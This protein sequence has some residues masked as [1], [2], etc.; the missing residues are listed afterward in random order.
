MNRPESPPAR[1]PRAWTMAAIPLLLAAGSVVSAA[2]SV[3]PAPADPPSSSASSPADAGGGSALGKPDSPADPSLPSNIEQLDTLGGMTQ[4]RLR[5]NGMTLLLVPNHSAPVITFL[6]VYHVGSR[7][8]APGNTGSA[9]LL[10]HMLFNKST[11]NFGRANG[12]R[13]FQEVLFE[14]GAD[15]SSSNMTT[16]YDRMTGYSTLPANKLE[17]AMRIASDRLGRGLILD[18][19]RQPEMSVVRNEYEIGENNPSQ[20]LFKAVIA[21]AIVAHPYHW[22]TIGYRSDI[23]GVSTETLRQHYRDF[24]WPDNTDAVLVGDFEPDS[25]LALFDREFGAF[26]HS[27]RPIPKV[28]TV[29][30]PQ[31]GE[32][33]VIVRRPGSVGI[34]QIAYIRP[35]ALDPD[36]I[37]IEVLSEI[38]GDGINSRLYQ[39]LVETGQASDVSSENF[40]LRD[41]YP[42]LL[43]ATV[44]PSSTHE[45]V[46]ATLK[47]TLYEVAKNGVTPEE[48]ERAKKQ[49]EVSVIRGRD[50]TYRL[51]SSL[52]EAIASASWQWFVGYPDA[53][54]SVTADDV[55][56]VASKYLIPDHATVGWFVPITEE[57]GVG[58][59]E[60][61]AGSGKAEG[62]AG[63]G[64]AAPGSAAGENTSTA[65]SATSAESTAKSTNASAEGSSSTAQ[66]S[67]AEQKASRGETAAATGN[68]AAS[69]SPASAA[70]RAT[71]GT[72]GSQ[73][74]NPI[75]QPGTSGSPLGASGSR[76]G[77]SASRSGAS[78]SQSGTS[79]P[80]SGASASQSRTFEDRT[81]HRVLPN[82]VIL[83]IVENPQA[84]NVS[85]SG[86][87]FA[88][89]VLAP[90]GAPAV[91][92][93]T[94]RMLSRGTTSR[95]KLEIASLLDGAGA[96]LQ[97]N[98]NVFETDITGSSLS[99]DLPLLLEILADELANPAFSD[100]ELEKA[101][102]E[103]KSDV[104]R[105]SE[106]T[107]TR[108]HE[109][110]SQIVYPKGH[111][112]HAPTTDEMLQS[113][114]A[115]SRDDIA[116]FHRE[117]FVGSS[118]ILAISGD[119]DAA[120]TASLIEK[121]FGGLPTGTRPVMDLPRVAPGPA[122][123][124]VVT[125]PGKANM[126]FVFGFASG[127][128]RTDPDYDA[129]VLA[130]AA[131]G[132]DA[133][134]SRI[135][136]RVRD[137]EGLS[138]YL[139]SR[140]LMSD[141]LDGEW[142]V[143]VAVA[144]QNLEKAMRS[145]REEFE[146]YCR[147]GI[148][149][150]ELRVQKSHFAGNYQVRLGSNAGIAAALVE[151]E[152]FG[153]GP[154]YLDDYP[155]RI[156]AVTR[157]QVDAAIRDH[158]HPENLSLVVAGD[159][160]ELPDSP[161]PGR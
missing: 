87:V 88:G 146:K 2:P 90:S 23:E 80:Q 126:D 60:G 34:V 123:R 7:N 122:E 41:P 107:Y 118:L 108:A 157:E 103:M 81:T 77:T 93:L 54:Q 33:R 51:A 40:T 11:E 155:A 135:G 106:Q 73:S 72:P 147:E 116:T 99:A 69:T 76:S 149:D 109:R 101:K 59:P 46:E 27:S 29:E 112:L 31:E 120:A 152:K 58:A 134:S 45:Q 44:A 132:Q 96:R 127:L 70:T 139:Y 16:W 32:R 21:A 100:E 10:E 161:G 5:S 38:L 62:G 43:E 8:E 61:A 130:N 6:M 37:P 142:M 156:R 53:I 65:E 13:T 145:T 110:L 82:G 18:S 83:D 48:L 1:F 14:A 159:I 71:S 30:P 67:S 105:A 49:I 92:E 111:P 26:P 22:D 75:S 144:P 115:A 85:L 86:L 128:R 140:F 68:H 141:L 98:S 129:A 66:L 117:H 84:P 154:A 79:G 150:E 25:A 121:D 4:Y 137:T 97:I 131:V 136:R 28:I 15:F 89:E 56:R 143:D 12:H 42:L 47:S 102:S 138:Y 153:F 113:I 133:L 50:G 160:D 36:F 74:G 57:A 158:L 151:A 3:A 148:T 24:F 9:H 17:L 20:A 35:G 125:M 39:A 52:G 124:E 95:G 19:E 104:L 119:I 114:D 55:Q 63:S 64:G 91:P 94:A 78:G